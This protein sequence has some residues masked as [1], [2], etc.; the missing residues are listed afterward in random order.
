MLPTGW[1]QVGTSPSMG[2]LLGKV[3]NGFW[4]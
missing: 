4:A 2:K 1:K 3:C